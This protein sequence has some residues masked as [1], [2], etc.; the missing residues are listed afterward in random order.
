[1]PPKI[2][3]RMSDVSDADNQT[4][5]KFY[6]WCPAGEKCSKGHKTLGGYWTEA[7]A[8]E[9]VFTHLHASSY[10]L[11]D[12]DLARL[13]AETALVEKHPV[14][15]GDDGTFEP[16]ADRVPSPDGAPASKRRRHDHQRDRDHHRSKG[17][18]GA[19]SSAAGSGG[20]GNQAIVKA[21]ATLH[22]Q[23]TAQTRNSIVFVKAMTK[24]E[25]ALRLAAK[26]SRGAMETFQ[27]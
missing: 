11:M 7:R 16:N 17:S 9:A 20:K 3:A 25:K 10:H 4:E 27:D 22:Q 14:A 2:Q 18:G 1:M 24:A 5:Y 6:T 15:D 8:R 13:E 12:D 23:I 26:V 19:S 21:S